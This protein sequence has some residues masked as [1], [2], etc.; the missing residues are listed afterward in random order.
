MKNRIGKNNHC[1]KII[2]LPQ[3]FRKFYFHKNVVSIKNKHLK[4]QI[5]KKKQYSTEKNFSIW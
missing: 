3:I 1:E 2:H 4:K 5:W